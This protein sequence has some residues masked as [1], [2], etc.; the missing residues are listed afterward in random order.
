MTTDICLY[1]A[2]NQSPV[3]TATGR[4]EQALAGLFNRTNIDHADSW[5]R[6]L[7]AE[8]AELK[9]APSYTKYGITIYPSDTI[10]A[11]TQ[12]NQHVVGLYIDSQHKPLFWLVANLVA[13]ADAKFGWWYDVIA[14]GNDNDLDHRIVNQWLDLEVNAPDEL[15]NLGGF[16]LRV[17]L[18][19]ARG[20]ELTTDTKVRV[21][22][23]TPLASAVKMQQVVM[24]HAT[25]ICDTENR[26]RI[27]TVQQ[28]NPNPQT[29]Y[30][31][32]FYNQ[33]ATFDI[34]AHVR[35]EL[36]SDGWRGYGHIVN[37]RTQP[38]YRIWSTFSSAPPSNAIHEEVWKLYLEKNSNNP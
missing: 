15:Y 8:I 22:A 6:D 27:E 23:G 1:T 12:P 9:L 33:R 19:D 18:L 37:N 38:Y 5:M 29:G 7:Y 26:Y 17:S 32:I 36:R 24:I 13:M 34:D 25:T 14:I 35:W 16:T 21:P 20:Y 2:S 31:G 28:E 10:F 4:H 11:T 3:P 30:T